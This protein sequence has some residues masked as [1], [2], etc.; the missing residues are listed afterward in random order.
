MGNWKWEVGNSQNLAFQTE[1][2]GPE[3]WETG[4]KREFT[5]L[6]YPPLEDKSSQNVFPRLL[7]YVSINIDQNEPMDI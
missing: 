5:F 4:H 2:W 1:K 7:T 3:K 6:K